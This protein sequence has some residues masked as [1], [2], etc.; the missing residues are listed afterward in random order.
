MAP[1]GTVTV[2]TVAEAVV[3]V[4]WVAPKKTMLFAGVGSKLVPVMVTVVPIGP[5][6]GVKEEMIGTFTF[7]ESYN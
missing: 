1:V 2:S 6:V 7:S 3:T 5:L 4:A